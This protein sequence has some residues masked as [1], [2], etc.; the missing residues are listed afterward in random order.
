MAIISIPKSVSGS[1]I[2][3]G[4]IVGP[5]GPLYQNPN[6]LNFHKY[7][8]D[9]E[10]ATKGHVVQLIIKEQQP[11]TFDDINKKAGETFE[12]G[13][14]VSKQI[15]EADGFVAGVQVLTD[16]A[17]ELGAAAATA[18]ETWWNNGFNIGAG[19][20][21]PKIVGYISLYMP[22]TMNFTY[23][24]MYDKVSVT[25]AAAEALDLMGL[26][27]KRKLKKGEAQGKFSKI[28]GGLTSIVKDF[29]SNKNSIAT[30]LAKQAGYAINPQQ[31]M[32]FNGVDLRQFQLSFV[33][34]PTSAQ[35]AREV[36][37][38]VKLIKAH[39]RP[40]K[41]EG[42]F[43]MFFH[44]PSIFGVQFLF[45]GKLNTKI[46][47]VQDCVIQSVDVNYAP[48]G[49][50]AHTDGAPVQ[51]TLTINLMETQIVDKKLIMNGGY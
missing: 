17:K 49:W 4:L 43:G 48:N 36:E 1:S 33:F 27:N 50:V 3:S 29:A 46:P 8:K 40:E 25:D 20:K 26:N 15:Q 31:S 28:F 51:T 34:T 13:K 32:L 44:P 38:I 30:V 2:P 42:G 35:E 45:N 7:P 9:L 10:T 22:D 12:S 23:N 5:L 14:A 11:I 21:D 18:A 47:K 39:S 6:A 16:K 41:I 19:M 24:T 37:Q